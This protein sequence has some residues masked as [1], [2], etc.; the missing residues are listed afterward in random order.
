[1]AG[2]VA[3]A[4]AFIPPLRRPPAAPGP[5]TRSPGP[6]EQ[7]HRV[8]ISSVGTDEHMIV[9]AVEGHGAITEFDTSFRRDKGRPCFV[10]S[11]AL[12]PITTIAECVGV[13][14]SPAIRAV[15]DRKRRVVCIRDAM[16]SLK[17][18]GCVGFGVRGLDRGEREDRRECN[19]SDS[20]KSNHLFLRAIH[21]STSNQLS[22]PLSICS[23]IVERISH[24]PGLSALNAM[25]TVRFSGTST[26]SM[27]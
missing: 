8:S 15:S 7:A 20:G 9:P 26:V 23:R 5:K 21:P 17:S 24:F 14:V 10:E 1:M 6:S 4:A 22:T 19:Q 2:P 18:R 25:R 27:K 3:S 13:E 16:A 11:S 12:T